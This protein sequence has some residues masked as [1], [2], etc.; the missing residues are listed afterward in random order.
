MEL[1]TFWP[2]AQCLNQMLHSA[3]QLRIFCYPNTARRP[4]QKARVS[5]YSMPSVSHS[6]HPLNSTYFDFKHVNNSLRPE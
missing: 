2:V 6:I 4:V 3:P 5:G 1:A